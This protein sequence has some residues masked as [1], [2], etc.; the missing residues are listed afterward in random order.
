MAQGVDKTQRIG[1]R[2][3]YKML[4]LNI[5]A[6]LANVQVATAA[7]GASGLRVV[8]I[9]QRVA[10]SSPTV[11]TDIFDSNE[12]LST[13]KGTAC[14]V[15]YDKMITVN[16]VQNTQTL[17]YDTGRIHRKLHFK[18]NNHVTFL[19]AASSLPTDYKDIYYLVIVSPQYSNGANVAFIQGEWFSRLS[20]K[21]V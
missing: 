19:N 21:D 8:V 2:V 16:Q 3:Q 5:W 17:A 14:R 1:N 9:Q 20:F 10:F 13:I 6:Q 15:L 4:T 12:F 18:V 11:Y 7:Y